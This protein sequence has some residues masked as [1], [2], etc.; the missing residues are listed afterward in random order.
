MSSHSCQRRCFWRVCILLRT[1][2]LR[3]LKMPQTFHRMTFSEQHMLKDNWINSEMPLVKWH[4]KLCS[5]KLNSWLW[6]HIREGEWTK[7]TSVALMDDHIWS[8]DRGQKSIFMFPS[9]Y[10]TFV[11]LTT[12]Y[13][14]SYQRGGRYSLLKQT[15]YFL[16]VLNQSNRKLH[17]AVLSAVFT[18]SYW[19]SYSHNTDTS[20]AN[21]QITFNLLSA[22]LH[23]SLA[24][25]P[26]W[27]K[28]WMRST[29]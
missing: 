7:I 11:M 12:Q 6:I 4:L 3:F 14:L 27:P 22:L 21:T 2:V 17:A 19:V 9:L 23:M 10:Q 13:W 1:W 15:E 28:F 26:R 25:I 5:M 16:K 20:T 8:A 18:W 24:L 29:T